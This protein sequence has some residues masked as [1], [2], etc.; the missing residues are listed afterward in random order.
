MFRNEALARRLIKVACWINKK[1]EVFYTLFDFLAVLSA[2]MHWQLKTLIPTLNFITISRSQSNLISWEKKKPKEFNFHLNFEKTFQNHNLN[3]HFNILKLKYNK[4]KL[5]NIHNNSNITNW[6]YSKWL[7]RIHQRE[8]T[9]QFLLSAT[10][11]DS[12]NKWR[13]QSLNNEATSP[14]RLNLFDSIEI[15]KT[16]FSFSFS[17]TSNL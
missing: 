4:K 1:A 12:S 5:K 2:A 6:N 11:A 15:N 9:I 7:K 14:I 16:S 10:I 13:R 3:Y 17:F 8:K